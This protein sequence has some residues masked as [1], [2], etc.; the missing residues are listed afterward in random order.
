MYYYGISLGGIHG[1]LFAALTPDVE[2]FGLDVPAIGFG[3]LLQRSTQFAAFD[4]IIQTVGVIDPMQN[5]ILISLIH[6]LWVSADPAGFARHITTDRL[7]GSGGTA[8]K[9][10]YHQSWLDLQVSNQCTEIAVRTL[11]IPNL[12][13][14]LQSGLTN[15]PDVVGPVTSAN[16]TRDSG[17]FD[18]FNPLHQPFIPPLSNII[19]PNSCDPHNGPRQIPAAVHQLLAFLQPGGTI[20]NT[21]VGT[22]DAVD[23]SETPTGGRCDGTSPVLLQGTNCEADVDCGG[24]VCAPHLWCDPLNP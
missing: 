24:G 16:V 14:S 20:S 1:T 18:I 10:L 23:P 4:A 19:P 17:A 8:A 3:C 5:A 9:L 11:G 15:I 7:P 6:E 13:G 21:C 12:V 2:R 22:C